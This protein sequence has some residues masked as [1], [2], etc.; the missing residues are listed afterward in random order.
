MFFFFIIYLIVP[1]DLCDEPN[2]EERV[3]ASIEKAL[4][5]DP[6]NPEA[7][8]AKASYHLIKGEFEDATR[9]I[10]RSLDMWLPA[11]ERSVEGGLEDADE[12]RESP[13]LLDELYMVTP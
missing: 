9:E 8:Q 7:V 4:E 5:L 11:F 1:A 6:S 13:S 2:A 12:V 3:V 10:K